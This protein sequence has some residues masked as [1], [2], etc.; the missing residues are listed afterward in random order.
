MN[1]LI[2]VFYW[3]NFLSLRF[4]SVLPA[5]DEF[6]IVLSDYWKKSD[7]DSDQF[8]VPAGKVPYYQYSASWGVQ[9]PLFFLVSFYKH[10][11]NSAQIL[12]A[13]SAYCIFLCVP[14]YFGY[15]PI[16]PITFDASYKPTF[17]LQRINLN[18]NGIFLSWKRWITGPFFWLSELILLLPNDIYSQLQSKFKLLDR[19][20]LIFVFVLL[21]LQFFGVFELY[22]SML[23]KFFDYVGVPIANKPKPKSQF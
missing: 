2:F 22:D 21:G 11:S 16:I 4:C 12:C 14:V 18:P 19:P 8:I 5:K 13:V 15:W 23:D 9:L 1:F 20:Q 17:N 7:S 6:D 10:E 3:F